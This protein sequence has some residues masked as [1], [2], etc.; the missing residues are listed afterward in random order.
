MFIFPALV[1]CLVLTSLGYFALWTSSHENTSKGLA[2]FGKVLSIILF[3][4]AGLVFLVGAV[5]SFSPGVHE[6]IKGMTMGSRMHMEEGCSMEGMHHPMPGMMEKN[7]AG[8]KAEQ[9][10]K[11]NIQ[12]M[13]DMIKN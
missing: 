12:D 13:K 3:V 5:L 1:A 2:G 8:P 6:H 4:F 9:T 10:R 11:N 7:E